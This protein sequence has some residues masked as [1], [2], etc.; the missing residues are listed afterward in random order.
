MLASEIESAA[1]AG[2]TEKTK[3]LLSDLDFEIEG[4][5]VALNAFLTSVQT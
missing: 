1:R 2:E 5:S 4:F 3:R